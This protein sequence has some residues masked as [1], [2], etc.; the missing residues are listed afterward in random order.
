MLPEIDD[1]SAGTA[2]A[3][4]AEAQSSSTPHAAT[5]SVAVSRFN[6]VTAQVGP[7]AARICKQETASL[8]NFDCDVRLGVDTQMAQRNAYFTYADPAAKRDPMI[9]VTVPMLRDVQSDDELAFV[10]GHEYGHLIARHIQKQEQQAVA[11]A[12]IAGILTAAANANNPYADP[13][14]V[15]DNMELGSAI[16][17]RAFSQSYELES[18]TLGTLITRSAGFDPVKG[19]RFFA[20]GEAPKLSTG[21]LSFWGTHPPN[22]TRLATVIATDSR[23]TAQGNIARK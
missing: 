15:S 14:A 18:D 16:G 11:G 23:I 3:M 13:N 21:Q 9:K 6:R 17:H 10:I 1:A 12:L 7:V 4:F 5:D 8:K 2:K 22:Q 19:A 20:R